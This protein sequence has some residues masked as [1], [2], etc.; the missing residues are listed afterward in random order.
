MYNCACLL[1]QKWM[2]DTQDFVVYPSLFTCLVT[3]ELTQCVC[4]RGRRVF[5][6]K[7]ICIIYSC[8]VF[9]V[10]SLFCNY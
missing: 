2:R 9:Y 8:G 10:G 6:L 5:T 3:L 4:L 1:K 7:L